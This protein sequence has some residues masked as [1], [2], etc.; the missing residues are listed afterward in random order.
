MTE[1]LLRFGH[2]INAIS[3][4]QKGIL[5]LFETENFNIFCIPAPWNDYTPAG[6][7]ILHI[8]HTY[9]LVKIV[10]LLDTVF[11]IL[12]KKNNQVTFLHIYHHAVM[13]FGCYLYLKFMSGGGHGLMLG[14]L[15]D[16]LS[17]P[18]GGT[19]SSFLMQTEM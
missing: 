8:S 11:F 12:R 5:A 9:Y 16:T 18:S 15:S 2:I 10:D 19:R 6:L 3:R 17:S 7:K 1:E 4:P 14:E 13:V